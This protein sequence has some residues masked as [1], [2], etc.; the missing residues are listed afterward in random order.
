MNGDNN[1]G[2]DNGCGGVNGDDNVTV[3]KSR[4]EA[5]TMATTTVMMRTMVA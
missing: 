1:D 2:E 5:T 4:E 3:R